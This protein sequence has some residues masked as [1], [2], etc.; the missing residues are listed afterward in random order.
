MPTEPKRRERS[1]VY[2]S[3]TEEQRSALRAMAAGQLRTITAVIAAALWPPDGVP[4][5]P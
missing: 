3:L 1:G 5:K 4:P 2:V